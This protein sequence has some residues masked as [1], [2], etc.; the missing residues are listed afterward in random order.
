MHTVYRAQH[1]R[2][3][4]GVEARL[5]ASTG[6]RGHIGQTSQLRLDMN[7]SHTAHLAHCTVMYKTD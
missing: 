7:K 5:F 4:R 1:Y 2:S 6:D 3:I